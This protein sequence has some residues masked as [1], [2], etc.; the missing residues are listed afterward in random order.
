[1]AL[2]EFDV[3]EGRVRV[4]AEGL[5]DGFGGEHGLRAGVG[6]I[7]EAAGG[8]RE[9]QALAGEGIFEGSGAGTTTA[10]SLG[11]RLN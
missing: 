7:E 6:L 3:A 4:E 10:A 11:R 1:M 9:A 2:G 5:V 8:Q